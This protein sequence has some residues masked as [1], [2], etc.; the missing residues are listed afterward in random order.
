MWQEENVWCFLGLNVAPPRPHWNWFNIKAI[1]SQ[2]LFSQYIVSELKLSSVVVNSIFF[3]SFLQWADCD[4]FKYI[5]MNRSHTVSVFIIK[6]VKQKQ[7]IK[8]SHRCCW[9]INCCRMVF[10]FITL[11]RDLKHFPLLLWCSVPNSQT[12]SWL[13]KT[14][15]ALFFICWWKWPS[16]K[17]PNV[18][19]IIHCGP[20]IL[21]ILCNNVRFRLSWSK[22]QQ[23]DFFVW[24]HCNLC[25]LHLSVRRVQAGCNLCSNSS[26]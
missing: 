9:G 24:L 10:H 2:L 6:A 15:A 3:Q 22:S 19:S 16:R 11:P 7:K 25:G 21:V 4:F 23:D 12:S 5:L 14:S 17:H 20:T 1:K 18:S 26:P 8:E 13:I